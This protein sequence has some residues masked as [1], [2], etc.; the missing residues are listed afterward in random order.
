MGATSELTPSRLREL[1]PASSI[2]LD[3]SAAGRNDAVRAAGALLLD[4]G[5]VDAAYVG[6]MLEREGIV[7]TY[8]G[9]GI[10]L[11]HATVGS[12]AEVL[13]DA[14]ALLRFPDEIDWDGDGVRVVIAIAAQ[15]RGYIGLISQLA[16]TLLEPGR[17][18][19]LRQATTVEEVYD[20]FA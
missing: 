4:A 13:G 19:A 6:A 5:A 18:E 17:A 7:S 11:P 10:A 8:V 12:R 9:E 15:G 1:L 2:V 20:V 16:S 3:A 14:L